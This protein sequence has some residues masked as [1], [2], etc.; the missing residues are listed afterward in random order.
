MTESPERGIPFMSLITDTEYVT[1]TETFTGL[2]PAEVDALW[3]EAVLP[4]SKLFAQ[5]TALQAK[6]AKYRK[7][8]SYYDAQADGFSAKAVEKFAEA[9]KLNDELQ[10]PFLAEW[11]ARGGWT[12][13]YVVP[14]GHIHKSTSCHT[15]YPTTLVSWLPEQSGWDEEKIVEAAGV[16]ACTVCYPSAPVEALRAAALAASRAGECPGSRT[17]DHDSS[18][19]QYMQRRAR[20]NHCHK[21]VSATSTGKLRGH[22]A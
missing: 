18:G 13:A 12:R 3:I 21:T 14:D 8:G 17:Y 4:A 6:A 19:L 11:D 2:T 9:R 7:H 10:A 22:K 5:A 1:T 20:C 15:L 16:H